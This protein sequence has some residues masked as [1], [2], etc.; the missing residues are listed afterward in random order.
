LSSEDEMCELFMAANPALPFARAVVGI[1]AGGREFGVCGTQACFDMDLCSQIA[2]SSP[3]FYEV[4]QEPATAEQGAKREICQVLVDAE[5]A[6]PF[7]NWILPYSTVLQLVSIALL[8]AVIAQQYQRCGKVEGPE[9]LKRSLNLLTALLGSGLGVVIASRSEWFG[10]EHEK[11]YSV[12]E[13]IG[14]SFWLL[15]YA[16]DVVGVVYAYE[17][18][19]RGVT[20]TLRWD[21]AVHHLATIAIICMLRNAFAF[22]YAPQLYASIS[23]CLLLHVVA[24]VPVLLMFALRGFKSKGN[25]EVVTKSLFPAAVIKLGMHAAIN[26][27][28]LWFF[29]AH[30]REASRLAHVSFASWFK[31]TYNKDRPLAADAALQFDWTGVLQACFPVLAGLLFC[32]QVWTTVVLWR[33]ASSACDRVDS[34]KGEVEPPLAC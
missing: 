25:R 23:A 19:V 8:H 21:L 4:L 2:E 26:S 3:E 7:N 18:I 27:T 31:Q 16:A 9:V 28:S 29:Y 10:F 34:P 12:D 13:A 5:A 24:D 32:T 20:R 14:G 11:T 1:Q 15:S 6:P 17:V 22:D 30:R 33:V